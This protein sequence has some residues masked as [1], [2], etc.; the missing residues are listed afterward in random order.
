MCALNQQDKKSKRN[1]RRNKSDKKNCFCR[2]I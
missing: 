2:S 1:W